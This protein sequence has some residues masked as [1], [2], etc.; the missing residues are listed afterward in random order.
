MSLN[1]GE[2]QV[3]PTLAGI[4]RDHV[5]RYEWAAS[6]IAGRNPHASV[7]DLACGVG[8]GSHI[9]A[10][11]G[12]MVSAKDR[13]GEA[14]AYAK[15]HYAHDRVAFSCEDVRSVYQLERADAAVCFET[16]EHIEEP[17][18]LLRMLRAAAPLLLVSVPNED[19]MPYRGPGH[20]SGYAFHFRHYTPG[21]FEAL[22]NAAGWRVVEWWGQEG[23]E[24]EVERNVRGRTLLA[25]CIRQD[26]G[27]YGRTLI[28]ATRAANLAEQPAKSAPKHVSIV[29]LGP[30]SAQY[31]S[32]TR[33]MGGRHK[34]SDETWVINAYGDVLAHDRVF[35][36]DDV[37]IQQIRAD[38]E[39]DSNIA[40]MLEWLKKHPGPIVTSRAHPDYPGLVEFPLEE[41]VNEFDHSYFNNTAAY[42]VA[43]AIHIGVEKLSLFGM[44]FTYPNAHDAEKGRA[45]VEYWL[46]QA[47]ARGVKIVIPKTSTLLDALNTPAER[48]Y[49]YDTVDLAFKREGGRISVTKTERA[50][51]PTAEEIEES[52][53]HKAHPNALVREAPET[54]AH[55]RAPEVK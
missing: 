28:E 27:V 51:L 25:V 21:Q 23:A 46:G 32:I 52:Y 4:R 54:V 34:Y 20:E 17:L 39:P 13:D 48:F 37:R 50:E 55:A 1:N 43:Y 22:L 33:G 18:S 7:L 38:A 19:A 45:C 47:V 24:S 26:E 30:S 53:D 41:V 49:G 31:V 6:L 29:G 12:F 36:M 42:A 11:A 10:D 2:R 5:A 15:R 16:V 40:A 44:D 35:H 9:L 8:Y 14:I 3:A